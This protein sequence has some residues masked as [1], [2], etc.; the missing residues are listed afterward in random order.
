MKRHPLFPFQSFRPTS[1][2]FDTSK[3]SSIFQSFNFSTFLLLL[4]LLSSCRSSHYVLQSITPHRI[5]V[6]AALDTHPVAAAQQFIAPYLSGVDSLRMPL[7]GH[8]AQF[9][10]GHRPES[11]LSNWVADALVDGA[12]R[13]GYT[14][15]FGLCN[16]GGLR[17]SMP[18]G[19][20][21]RGDILAISPFDNKLTVLQM[22]GT[23]VQE[24]MHNIAAVHGEGLS[25]AARLVITP[26]GQLRSATIGGQPIAPDSIYSIATLDYLADGN[27]RLYALRNSIERSVTTELIS[28]TLMTQLRL[29][30]AQGRQATSAIEGRIIVEGGG[31]QQPAAKATSIIPAAA[32]T[33]I[34]LFDAA[35]TSAKSTSLLIVHTN[36]THSCI[37]PLSNLIPD[38]A[39]A[40][41]G[42]ALRRAALM[43]QLRQQDPDLL[44]LD[45]GDFSQGSAFYSL[46]HG[47]VEVGLMN[48]MHYDAATIGNHE[49]DFG[50]ENMARIFRLAQF[51]IVCCNYDFSGTPVEGLV[52]PY[53]IIKRAGAKI[54]ILGVS[55]QLEGLVSAKTCTGV[56][57]TDPIAAAQPVAD[58]LRN[59]E[60]CDLV[61]CLS[62]LGWN[63][64]GVSDE[65]FIA[66]THNIDLV[67]GGH[68]HTYFTA[69]EVLKNSNGQ[70]VPDNQMGKNGRYVGTLRLNL[71]KKAK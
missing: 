23:D 26:D 4:L 5:E 61:I 21:R 9:M 36:D 3:N 25:T 65:E 46:Y 7:V 13:L 66:A 44:L 16:M 51:P 2:R 50:L 68:S 60:R 24:L 22:R 56:R 29:L 37:E 54:G 35:A 42:G 8:S 49:F 38:T 32:D 27:D 10:P 64:S 45:C 43:Q 55:P 11:L 31:S 48:L 28:E 53:I 40:N 59:V 70:L 58:Y 41:K 63:I 12:R 15:D 19:I 20:V 1:D 30:E 71:R 34:T 39:H 14:V 17:A 62:H 67:L 57:Y 69:P 6:T 47:D 33:E 18:Q 52:R